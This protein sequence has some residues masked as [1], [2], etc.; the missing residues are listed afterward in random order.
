MNKSQLI[1]AM[2]EHSGL[3]KKQSAAALAA[4]TDTVQAT[5]VAG[6]SIQLIG[7]FSIKPTSRAARTGVNPSTGKPLEI[8]ASKGARLSLSKSFKQALNA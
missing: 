1:S 2:A 6:D 3:N 5:I 8:A 7:A 4:F